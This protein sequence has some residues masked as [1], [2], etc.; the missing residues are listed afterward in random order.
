MFK[1]NHS[2]R[3]GMKLTPP[4]QDRQNFAARGMR[5]HWLAS[6][7]YGSFEDEIRA[8]HQHPAL[9]VGSGVG[10]FD[11]AHTVVAR[12]PECKDVQPLLNVKLAARTICLSAAI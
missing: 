6:G 2:A 12:R 1:R 4:I 8:G 10:A 5:G 9:K 3:R 7:E 11:W